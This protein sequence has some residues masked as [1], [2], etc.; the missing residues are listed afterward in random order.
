M[1]KA[2]T[3]TCTDYTAAGNR[4]FKS[5]NE[6]LDACCSAWNALAGEPT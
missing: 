3:I 2:L 1:P 4:I 5:Y 6:I